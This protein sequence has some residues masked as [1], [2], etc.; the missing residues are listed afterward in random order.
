MIP[1]AS[2]E[3]PPSCHTGKVP[4]DQWGKAGW[5]QGSILLVLGTLASLILQ[6]RLGEEDFPPGSSGPSWGMVQDR[7]LVAQ[8]GRGAEQLSLVL[9]Q[10]AVQREAHQG[11]DC[12]PQ[13]H[14]EPEGRSSQLHS[15][16]VAAR[17]ERKDG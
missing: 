7:E 17:E 11:S 4:G 8:E 3:E 1:L 6:L 16:Q 12:S 5:C 2:R 10:H 14:P 15:I 13:G 9:G